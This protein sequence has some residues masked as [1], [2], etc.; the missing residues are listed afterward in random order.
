[1]KVLAFTVVIAVALCLPGEALC[2][3][4]LLNGNSR[5]V[6]IEDIGGG[7]RAAGVENLV[8]EALGEELV[9]PSRNLSTPINSQT[10]RDGE[11][12]WVIVDAPCEM[13]DVDINFVTMNGRRTA[14]LDVRGRRGY[15]PFG[16][17]NAT[18]NNRSDGWDEPCPRYTP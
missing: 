8:A 9:T 4:L 3:G 6:L 17:R 16:H 7:F 15:E 13:V 2:A 18:S 11:E 10:E 14:S 1:M 12:D 5:R